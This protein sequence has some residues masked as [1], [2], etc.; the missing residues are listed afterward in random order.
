MERYFVQNNIIVRKTM[1]LTSNEAVKQ[2]ILAG[3]GYSVMPLI[4]IRN[5]IRNGELKIIPVKGLPIRTTWRLIWLKGKRHSPAAG[6]Y[7]KHLERHKQDIIREYFGWYGE[8][9]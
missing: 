6:A 4:G 7:L 1:E 9:S 5:E 8:F 3:L 2:S